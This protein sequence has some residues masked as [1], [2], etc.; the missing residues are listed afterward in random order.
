MLRTSLVLFILAVFSVAQ[1]PDSA[2]IRGKI[3]DQTRA[4]ISGVD[5]KVKSTSTA[6]ERT[7]TSDSTGT[8]SLSGLPV[9]SYTL[10][11]HKQGFGD[12]SRE[13]TLVGGTTAD[14]KL[15]MN[16]SAE[17]SQVVVTGTPG[18]IR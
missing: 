3:L 5:V 10:T 9:G 17:Q 1:T 15:Q 2:T 16:V 7:A 12:V 8:F 6:F 13:L 11:V 18:E 4:A 14:L